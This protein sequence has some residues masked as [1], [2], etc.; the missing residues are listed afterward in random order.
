MEQTEPSEISEIRR[1]T[2]FLDNFVS[3]HL[4]ESSDIAAAAAC[5]WKFRLPRIMGAIPQ[6]VKSYIPG[7]LVHRILEDALPDLHELWVNVTPASRKRIKDELLEDWAPTKKRI[8][9]D[10]KSRLPDADIWIAAA[11]DRLE[12]MAEVLSY[13]MSENAPP[14]R[15]LTEILITNPKQHHEG[16]VDAVLEYEN[17]AVT[18]E[19]KTYKEST[20]SKHDIIQT[21]ANGILINYR[22]GRNDT[23]FS[24]NQL[25]VMLP[26]GV[27]KVYPTER[28][29]EEIAD[30]KDYV[31]KCLQDI[32]VRTK[33]PFPA[34]CASC[35]YFDSCQFYRRKPVEFKKLE[36]RRRAWR[37]RYHVLSERANT[38][39]YE[40]YAA[41][42]TP[43]QLEKLG[44]A[45]FRYKAVEFDEK[46]SELTIE[47]DEP[48]GIF[49]GNPVRVMGVEGGGIPLLACVNCRGGVKGI[50]GDEV[51]VH[52]FGGHVEQLMN[53]PIALLRSEVDLTKADLQ[54][55]DL[56]ERRRPD[57]QPIADMLAGIINEIPAA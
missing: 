25:R 14:N 10:C 30:A 29:L 8:F 52:I 6:N 17:A 57:L 51:K 22:Y 28:R 49:E 56:I 16:I 11:E 48:E 26:D 41:Y 40:F 35:G 18:L 53:L 24:S 4:A 36:R 21:V 47:G 27:H 12:R 39:K 15:I 42:L 32:P 23:D 19:W 46:R 50:D 31:I 7:G 9:N 43:K 44:I 38:H 45:S 5:G 1:I 3:F 55:I 20:L 13:E 54:A 2:Q 34:I 33:F 37:F